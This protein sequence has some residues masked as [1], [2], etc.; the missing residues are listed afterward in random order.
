G[1]VHNPTAFPL[2][3]WRDSAGRIAR[4]SLLACTTSAVFVSIDA[5][6]D[7]V[8]V[9]T[10]QLA[11][12]WSVEVDGTPATAERDG[13]FRAVRVRG[14]RHAITWRYRPRSL[15]IGIALTMLAIFRMLLST[16]FVKRSGTKN[17][18]PRKQNSLE[19]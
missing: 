16:K 12:G 6:G 2:A 4:A 18:F 3:Y 5:P 7:G 8:V 14:G 13:V 19:V 15:A 1:V 9:V 11:S 17:I 10:Q